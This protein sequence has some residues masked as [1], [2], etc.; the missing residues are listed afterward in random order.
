MKEQVPWQ[1]H[2]RLKPTITRQI[3]EEA[4]KE[5]S[6]QYGTDQSFDRLHERGGFGVS[7]IIFLLF[8]RCKRL[9]GK[10]P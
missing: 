8:D 4:Y 2:E 6:A 1:T 9:E 3:A 10:K 5:Y 7:E